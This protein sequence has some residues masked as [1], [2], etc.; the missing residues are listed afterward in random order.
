M[1]KFYEKIG[2]KKIL[3]FNC[4]VDRNLIDDVEKFYYREKNSCFCRHFCAQTKKNINY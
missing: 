3:R 4:F 2:R 1:R